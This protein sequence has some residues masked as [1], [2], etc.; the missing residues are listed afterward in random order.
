[1]DICLYI[2]DQHAFEVQ[3]YAGNKVI[4]TPNLDRIAKQGTAFMNAYTPYPVCVPAR[5]SMLSSLYASKNGVMSNQSSLSSNQATFVHCLAISGYETVLCGRMHFIGADQRHGFL[6]RIAGDFTQSGQNRPERIQE[7]RGV[8]NKASQAGAS[9]V[10]YVGGGNSPVLEYD[11]YVIDN[12]LEYLS[13]DYDKPQFLCVGT[14][15]P[16]HP[17]VAPKDLYE[18]YLSKV[19]VPVS[20]FEYEEHPCLINLF[21]DKDEELIRAVRAAYYGMVEFEDQQIGKVYDAFQE[22]LSRNHREGIFI[23]VSDHGEMEG[24]RGYFGKNTFYESSVHIPLLVAGTNIQSNS[25]REGVVSLLDL[26]PTILEMTNSTPLS[27]AD[28]HSLKDELINNKD[29]LERMVCS[30]VGGTIFLNEFSYGQMLRYQNYKYIH[31][32]Q[33]E[34]EDVLYDLKKDPMESKNVLEEHRELV[35]VFQDYLDKTFV[36]SSEQLY[37]NAL[38]EKQNLA[39]LRKFPLDTDEMWH[40]PESAREYPNPLV[41]SNKKIEDWMEDI[42]VKKA[43]REK[44]NGT[45]EVIG[46]EEIK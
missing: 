6:K 4:D 32:D 34:K 46:G 16:H 38:K 21:Q 1:M 11:R 41:S 39:I 27:Y 20:S 43:H 31:Y 8:F 45:D 26:G 25:K 30:E 3:G 10:E 15:A 9:S 23:Y 28:G 29:D 36:T 37:A 17:F 13:K 33:F 40:C 44:N 35:K 18:K 2:S 12:A 42:K 24:Y 5:M 19:D 7:E 22:Y 14:Y